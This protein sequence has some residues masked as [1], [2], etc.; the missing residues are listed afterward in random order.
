[1]APGTA[2]Q[3]A[4]AIATHPRIVDA[5]VAAGFGEVTATRPA[6]DAVVACIQS[7]PPLKEP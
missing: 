2:W 1:L 3:A 6:V 4:R 7:L 5:A